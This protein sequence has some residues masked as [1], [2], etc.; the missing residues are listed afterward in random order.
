VQEI[1][2]AIAFQPGQRGLKLGQGHRGPAL[3]AQHSFEDGVVAVVEPLPPWNLEIGL[4]LNDLSRDHLAN[5][6]A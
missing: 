2:E 6:Q 4:I 1:R 3:V 5:A